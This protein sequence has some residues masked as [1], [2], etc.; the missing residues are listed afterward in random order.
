MQ[1]KHVPKELRLFNS[2]SRHSKNNPMLTVQCPRLRTDPSTAEILARL[3][4]E[5]DPIIK[6]YAPTLSLH[7]MLYLITGKIEKDPNSYDSILESI[8]LGADIDVD[9]RNWFIVRRGRELGIE[10]PT[11]EDMIQMMKVQS[12]KEAANIERKSEWAAL[13]RG[14]HSL[15]LGTKQGG[16]VEM[17][18]QQTNGQKSHSSTEV[19]LG[20][21]EV[22]RLKKEKREE[23]MLGKKPMLTHFANPQIAPLGNS[24][25]TKK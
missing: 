13:R 20:R 2:P 7:E 22:K 16:Q 18:P 17:Q 10:C 6:Q 9:S 25:L 5:V 19:R 12:A 24:E 8:L 14:S 11:H 21:I 15:S 1:P 4:A 23:E 3:L